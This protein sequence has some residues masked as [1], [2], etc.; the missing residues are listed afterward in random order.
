[1][2]SEP[3]KWIQPFKK[4]GAHGFTFHYEA[5]PESKK[6]YSKNLIQKF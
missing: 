2:V 4:A 1:M 3:K 6:N 5:V